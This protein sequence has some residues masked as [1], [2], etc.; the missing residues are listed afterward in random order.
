MKQPIVRTEIRGETLIIQI[1]GARREEMRVSRLCEKLVDLCSEV[2]SG[3]HVRVLVLSY[4]GGVFDETGPDVLPVETG[5]ASVVDA[6]AQLRQP[7]IAAIQGDAVGAG[8]EI[9][10]TCD[11]RIGTEGARF[12]LTHVCDGIIPCA[13]GTQRL[14]RL[15]GPGKAMEMIL[16]GETVEAAEARRIGLFHRIVPVAGLEGAAAALA[17]EMASRSPLAMS[18]VKEALRG[19]LDLTI[20]QGTRMEMDLYLLLFSTQDRIEGITAFKEKRKPE[21]KGE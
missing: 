4:K 3:N 2:S 16:T 1:A 14:P 8:L 11:I 9:A 10:L 20:D 21:F 6:L 5:P 12:G 19:G 7:V 13:G 18:Y 17:T 15:I